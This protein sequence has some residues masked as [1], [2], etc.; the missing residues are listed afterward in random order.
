MPPAAWLPR[1]PARAK[2]G[3]RARPSF[4]SLFFYKAQEIMPKFLGVE[5]HPKILHAEDAARID[6]RGEKRV[7]HVAVRALGREHAVPPRYFPDGRGS[8]GE[9]APPR[10]VS[11]ER[12]CILLQHLRGVALGVDGDGNESDPGAEVRPEP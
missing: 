5:A 3:R 11:P 6:D 9:E 4:A 12:K 7:V 8:A 2:P 1:E 10:E